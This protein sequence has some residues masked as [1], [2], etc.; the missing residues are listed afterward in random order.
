M[1]PRQTGCLDSDGMAADTALVAEAVAEVNLEITPTHAMQ[2]GFGGDT[3]TNDGH[4]SPPLF[5]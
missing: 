5:C 1:I 3:Q 2:A 4:L